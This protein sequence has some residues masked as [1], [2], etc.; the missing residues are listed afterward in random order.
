MY[1]TY[2]INITYIYNYLN[3]WIFFSLRIYKLVST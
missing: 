1:I 2:I 3:K